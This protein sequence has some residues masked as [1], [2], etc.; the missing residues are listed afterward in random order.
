MVLR[1]FGSAPTRRGRFETFQDSAG[2]WRWRL[3]AG[4]G[5]IVADSSE[6]YT[7]RADARNAGNRA[8]R[9]AYWAEEDLTDGRTDR[10]ET[11][12]ERDRRNAVPNRSGGVLVR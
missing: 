4:N 11:R 8:R 6:G 9:I 3:I 2:E 7:R 10:P 12:R 5:L 1:S